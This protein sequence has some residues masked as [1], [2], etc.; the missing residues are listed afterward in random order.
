MIEA[1]MKEAALFKYFETHE[2]WMSFSA[3]IKETPQSLLEEQK[4]L[5]ARLIMTIPYNST[6]DQMQGFIS[7]IGGSPD[8]LLPVL[9]VCVQNPNAGATVSTIVF[10]N[11]D[12]YLEFIDKLMADAY[13]NFNRE[14]NIIN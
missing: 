13:L 11:D 2:V 6:V 4:K 10:K 14:S 12:H 1:K 9:T 3:K 7:I 8:G 5:G